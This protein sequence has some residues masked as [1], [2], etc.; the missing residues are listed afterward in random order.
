MRLPNVLTLSRFVLAAILMM[1]VAYPFPLA[2]TLALL[3]FV[4]ASIT[5]YLDGHLARHVYGVTAF[6]KLMDPLADKVMITAA[7]VS[8]VGVRLAGWPH[9]LVPAPFVVIIISREFLVT[10]LR[11][12][13]AS[14]GEIIS[15]G[16]WGKHKTVWQ[17]IGVVVILLGYA[18][19]NDVLKL[20]GHQN[21]AEFDLAFGL[22][23]LAV[24]SAVLLITVASGGLYFYQH[25]HLISRHL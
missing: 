9:S 16:K 8:F 10:G 20:L 23:A 13:A 5:D 7:Y 22:I 24:S 21:L 19:R 12:L 6:G 4:A 14:Q 25:R 1:L 2:L 15:A 11:L 3:V 18:I 17:I